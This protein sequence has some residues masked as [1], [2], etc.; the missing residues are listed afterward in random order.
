MKDKSA[1][2]ISG[3]AEKTVF[4]GT[5]DSAESIHG[6][7]TVDLQNVSLL[8]E[9]TKRRPL[10]DAILRSEVEFQGNS[11]SFTGDTAVGKVAAAFTGTAR[12]F[13]GKSRSVRLKAHLAETHAAEIRNAFWDIFPDSLL[14]SGVEGSLSSDLQV[15]YEK[16][17][18]V[19]GGDLRLKGFTLAGE[20]DEYSIGPINGI[21]P[22]VYGQGDKGT[23]LEMSPFERP[24]FAR[25]KK[26][27]AEEFQADGYQRI[28]AGSF[29]YGFRLLSDITI[30]V[31][32]EKGGL[33]IGRFGANIF[34]GR[35]SGSAVVDL[36]GLRYRAGF[37]LDG[38]SLTRL[39]DNIEPI[40]GYISGRVNG[41]GMLGGSGTGLRQLIGKAE[42]WTFSTKDE[43]TK[44]SREFLQ[45]M[46]GTSLKAYI[47]DRRFDKGDM[48]LYLQNGFVIF[49]ELEISHRNFL[50]MQDLSVKVAPLSNKISIDDL[51]WSIVEAASRAGKKG[52]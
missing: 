9:K 10:K 34:G 24:D 31:K 7:L 38:L 32:Q 30:W 47:G 8:D 48:V 44:V 45:K 39:C 19:L 27:Y 43:E 3:E 14:Y 21:V 35:L 42:F 36:S 5:I 18:V 29:R 12:D 33:K 6:R 20:N 50:G 37:V 25:L 49:R 46:G 23:S 15:D 17:N 52:Q 28:D 2:G 11:C 22:I 41:A 4:S 51:M 40:K 26:S 1:Y 13:L 16:G